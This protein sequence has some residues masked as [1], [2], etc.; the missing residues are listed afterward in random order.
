[1]SEE[2][3]EA[4]ETPEI[5]FEEV[6]RKSVVGISSFLLRMVFLQIV[7]FI[8]SIFVS[9]FLTPFA[10]GVY[11]IVANFV[12]LFVF[13]SDIGLAA[14]L[15][16][17]KKKLTRDDLTTTFTIQQLLVIFLI[18]L[19]FLLLPFAQKYLKF[20]D[21]G[22]WLGRALAFSLLLAS[23]KSIPSVLLERKLAF[24]LLVI[25]EIIETIVFNGV[26]VGLAYFG[27]GIKSFTWAVLSRGVIGLIAIYILSPWR[28]G[29]GFNKKSARQLIRFGLPFQANT[30]L[31]WFKDNL[32]DNVVAL[33]LRSPAAFG[34]LS[35][36]K[37][38]SY[39]PKKVLDSVIRVTFPVYSRLQERREILGSA[40]SKTY[41]LLSVL[42]FPLIVGICALVKPLIFYL[43]GGDKW[44]PAI[45]SVYFFSITLLWGLFN[46]IATNALSAIGKIK[47]V[48]KFMVMITTATWLLTPFFTLK[49]GFNGAA[50]SWALTG[51]VSLWS[52]KKCFQEI[53]F[54]LLADVR[55]AALASLVMGVM[56]YFLGRVWVNNLVQLMITIGLGGL[57]YLFFIL[58][59]ERKRL[60]LE[61]KSLFREK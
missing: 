24:N 41:F 25:P 6:K 28:I 46:S 49:W 51:F 27:F 60:F 33:I 16:Q 29:F 39:Q 34:Y 58:L 1:M 9:R 2:M 36:A 40:M 31:A 7:T 20:G 26:L 13:F 4:V 11:G 10:F 15:I 45:P 14:A 17:K 47:V 50:L 48:L 21:D 43:Y 19:I 61:A 37:T 3:M 32:M 8:A 18:S 42:T 5:E 53:R 44:L 55:G 52:I 12:L 59:L 23:L 56:V 57:I 30:I 38:L 35:W 54:N 22:L